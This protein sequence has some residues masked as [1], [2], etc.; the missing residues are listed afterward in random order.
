MRCKFCKR[1]KAPLILFDKIEYWCLNFKCFTENQW[2]QTKAVKYGEGYGMPHPYPI[3]F[4]KYCC[5]FYRFKDADMTNLDKRQSSL[6]PLWNLSKKSNFKNQFF[7][8]GSYGI[9]KTYFLFACLREMIIL[10]KEDVDFVSETEFFSELKNLMSKNDN[11]YS[12][13]ERIDRIKNVR[14]LFYDDLGSASKSLE[15]KWGKQ[16]IHEIVDYRY[17]QRNPTFFTSNFNESDLST[18][19][20]ERTVD[21]LKEWNHFE[22]TEAPN[23]RCADGS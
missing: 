3:L 12:L 23:K 6:K 10:G 13:K 7:L 11:G 14:Y 16:L 21:R 18:A 4:V 2:K 5:K 17:C 19:L 8:S 1:E 15:G 20:D 9:G 22:F